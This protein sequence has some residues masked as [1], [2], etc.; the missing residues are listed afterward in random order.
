MK[1]TPLI[2]GMMLSVLPATAL[3]D[4]FLYGNCKSIKD[5]EFYR[6]ISTNGQI[7]YTNMLPP[8]EDEAKFRR[9]YRK[10]DAKRKQ[11]TIVLKPVTIENPVVD[12]PK[13]PSPVVPPQDACHDEWVSM[14]AKIQRL[15]KL[16]IEWDG[17]R[18]TDDDEEIDQLSQE[19][20][21]YISGPCNI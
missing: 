5:T 15:G 7:V 9:E 8:K 18:G 4:D 12:A 20:G 13:Q 14:R 17:V 21:E 10:W 19:V 1:L 6:C 16:L 3:A 2:I 11:K